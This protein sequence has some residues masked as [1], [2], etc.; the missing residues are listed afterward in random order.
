MSALV[1]ASGADSGAALAGA[2]QS[3]KALTVALAAAHNIVMVLVMFGSVSHKSCGSSCRMRQRA[4]R[5]LTLLAAGRSG[6]LL[7][8]LC[9]HAQGA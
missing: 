7:T 2:A 9:V 5:E 1:A 8:M 3:A 6:S 4:N